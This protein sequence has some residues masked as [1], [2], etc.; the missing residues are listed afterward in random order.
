MPAADKQPR[1]FVFLDAAGGTGSLREVVVS[2]LNFVVSLNTDKNDYQREQGVAAEETGRRLGVGV[3]VIHA[4]NDAIQQSQQLLNVIQSSNGK[5]PDGIIM[6]PVGTGLAQ[7][8]ATAVNA[9]IGWVVLNRDVD[10]LAELRRKHKVPAFGV[11]VDQE[12]IGRIQG[13]QIAALLPEGGLVLYI[14]GPAGNVAVTARTTGMQATKP[15]SVQVRTLRGSWTEESGYGA[16]AAWLRL[17]TSQQ[18]PVALIAAQSDNMAMGAR[19]AFESNMSGADRER[20]C[21]LPFLGVD[22]VPDPAQE[23]VRK[24]LLTASVVLPI[25]TST[26]LEM[27]VRAIETRTQP[28]ERNKPVPPVSFPAIEKLVERRRQ[29]DAS[30]GY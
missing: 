3:Q 2:R 13:R 18:T 10:Y 27:L 20:W 1:S 21:G 25:T 26:A 12:E 16:I 29:K 7:V 11:S 30:K 19:R 23:W 9:G 28:A 6:M 22:A 15:T 14:M 4:D 17:T 5:R 24:G 8:A